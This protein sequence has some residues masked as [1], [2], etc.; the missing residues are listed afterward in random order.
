MTSRTPFKA[1]LQGKTEKEL[2]D[3]ILRRGQQEL[4]D[5]AAAEVMRR[6]KHST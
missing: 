6:L 4:A 3:L 2:M 5:E 1:A